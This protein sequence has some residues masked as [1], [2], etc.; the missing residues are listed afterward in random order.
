MFPH[1]HFSYV[2][3]NEALPLVNVIMLRIYL[4]FFL[5]QRRS[6]FHQNPWPVLLFVYVR[7]SCTSVEYNSLGAFL[8]IRYPLADTGT[9]QLSVPLNRVLSLVYDCWH[10]FKYYTV[11][12]GTV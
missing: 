2:D 5:N 3:G 11:L 9:Q 12:Y 4:F 1:K 6:S 8:I 7:D 10:P